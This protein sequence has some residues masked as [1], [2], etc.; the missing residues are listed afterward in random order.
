MNFKN[1]FSIPDPKLSEQ[2]W[3][4]S[5]PCKEVKIGNFK[6]LLTQPLSSFW[7]Y[8]LGILTIW[9][10]IEFLRVP[11]PQV[12]NYW[13]SA[14]AI[15]WGVAALLAGTSYQAFSYYLKCH[16]RPFCAWT[17][18]WEIAYLYLQLLS[19]NLILVADALTIFQPGLTQSLCFTYAAL[20]STIYFF[21]VAYGSLKPLKNLITFELMI[22]FCAPVIIFLMCVHIQRYFSA[23]NELDLFL[24]KGSLGLIGITFIYFIYLK[25]GLSEKL[26]KK[27]IWFSENDILHV[28]LIIC[29]VA[30]GHFL[31]RLI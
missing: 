7:V 28:L 2:N 25:V 17:S 27:G 4:T 10:G 8:L 21:I 20:S 16:G 11:S 5:Q 3:R 30:V 31:P 29:V 26:W 22:T 13:W 9:A 14:S 23:P 24:I 18:W 19:V 15:L 12:K 6:F 1:L